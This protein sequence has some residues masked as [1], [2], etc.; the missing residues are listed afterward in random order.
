MKKKNILV[1]GGAGFIGSSLVRQ[2]AKEKNNNVVVFDSLEVGTR[3]HLNGIKCVILAQNILDFNALN[4]IM[5]QFKINEVYHLAARPF[6]PEGYEQPKKMIETN[7]IG[8]LNVMLACLNNQVTKVL[9]YSTSEVYGSAQTIP[10]DEY[11]PTIPHSIYAVAKLGADRIC[12]VLY[13]ERGLPVIILRQFNCYGERETHPYI[14]PEVIRQLFKTN[15]LHLGNIT[16]RR[17]FTYVND[18]TEAAIKLMENNPFG[19]VFNLGSNCAYTMQEL[20]YKI[21]VIM[22]KDIVIKQDLDRYRP[23]D[24]DH[25]QTSYAKVNKLTGWKPTTCIEDGLKKTV[26]WY[27]KHKRWSWE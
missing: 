1:T 26:D 4:S 17:D 16:A 25:L 19:E 6:I 23:F 2:L 18:A 12:H 8:T 11:H 21:G 22:N 13:K 27:K 3:E 5:K 9:H 10:M 24:V 14:I 15:I 7:T 20:V